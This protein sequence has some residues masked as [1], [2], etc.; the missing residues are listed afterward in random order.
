MVILSIPLGDPG[1]DKYTALMA[2]L[3][4][5]GAPQHYCVLPHAHIVSVLRGIVRRQAKPQSFWNWLTTERL[6][7]VYGYEDQ[8]FYIG[9]KDQTND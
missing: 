1:K 8:T 9:K 2:H 4:I 3:R 7:L 6:Y 5:L